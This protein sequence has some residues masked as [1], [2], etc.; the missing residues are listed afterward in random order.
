LPYHY[1]SS[2]RKRNGYHPSDP[3]DPL[4]DT[5]VFGVYPYFEAQGRFLN[6]D[7]YQ[8]ISAGRDGDFGQP[9]GTNSWMWPALTPTQTLYSWQAAT[10][11]T[12]APEATT[13]NPNR[14]AFDN[15]VNF[16]PNKL[17]VP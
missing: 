7:S 13:A 16:H 15:Q 4:N 14:Y 10:A 9:E 2:G 8:I 12:D 6:P 11:K 5:T 1:F 17:G 3:S